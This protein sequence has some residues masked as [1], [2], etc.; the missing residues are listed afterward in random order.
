MEYTLLGKT[1]LRISQIGF[2]GWG[3]AGGASHHPWKDMWRADDKLSEL[4]LQLA[5]KEGINFFDTALA[6]EDGHSERLISKTLKRKNIVIATKVPPLD[7]H[8]PAIDPD[9]RHTFP[10]EYI[11]QAAKKSYNNFGKRTID[12]L[13]LHGWHQRAG[14]RAGH[15]DGVWHGAAGKPGK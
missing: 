3:I 4:S 6:Y 10:K 8:W 1:K 2:G 15:R 5:Y 9:I 11:I 7:G 14:R 13:Q 12:I